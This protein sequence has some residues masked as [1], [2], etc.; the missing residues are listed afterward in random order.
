MQVRIHSKLGGAVYGQPQ[1]TQFVQAGTGRLAATVACSSGEQQEREGGRARGRWRRPASADRRQLDGGDSEEAHRIHELQPCNGGGQ[2][3][4]VSKEHVGDC[5]G[6]GGR[7]A[8]GRVGQQSRQAWPRC[9]PPAALHGAPPSPQPYPPAT[10]SPTPYVLL[11]A[12]ATADTGSVA[13]STAARAYAPSSPTAKQQATMSA[14]TR[15]SLTSMYRAACSQPQ[16]TGFFRIIHMPIHMPCGVGMRGG[17]AGSRGVGCT[18]AGAQAAR[19]SQAPLLRCPRSQ[20]LRTCGKEGHGL[21]AARKVFKEQ[22]DEARPHSVV[23]VRLGG[24]AACGQRQGQRDAQAH[25][26]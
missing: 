16:A 18:A 7:R 1:Q 8:R 3:Q 14:G 23:A 26:R 5:G 24:R 13:T 2:D 6:S 9:N 10:S 11:S 17:Q 21:G 15:I 20:A 4:Q 19:R 12:N 22:I 25:G